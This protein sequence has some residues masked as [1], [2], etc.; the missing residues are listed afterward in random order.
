ML[1]LGPIIG[2]TTHESTCIWIRADRD[3]SEFVLRIPSVGV[4]PFQYTGP[5]ASRY[6]TMLALASGLRSDRRY[7]YQIL[8]RGRRVSGGDGQVRTMPPPGSMLPQFMVFASCSD[9][10]DLKAW[11]QLA[12]FVRDTEPHAIFLIGDQA[13]QD[14]DSPGVDGNAY[15]NYVARKTKIDDVPDI[16]A[17]T[18]QQA[19]SRPDVAEVLRSCPIYMMWDDHDIRDGWGSWASD[20]PTIAA[21]TEQAATLCGFEEAYFNAAREMAWH[22]QHCRNPTTFPRAAL[23]GSD[24]Q[25]TRRFADGTF[26]RRTS[27]SFAVEIG[28]AAYV[29]CDGRGDR[30]LWREGPRVLGADQWNCLRGY[31]DHL[32][33]D[34]DAVVFVTPVPIVSADPN[35]LTQTIL[36]GRE[37]DVGMV[38]K[39]DEK[40]LRAYM[41]SPKEEQNKAQLETAALQAGLHYVIPGSIPGLPKLTE[42]VFAHLTNLHH[43]DIDDGR[44]QWCSERSRP[45]QVA[46]IRLALRA[47][48]SNRLGDIPRSTMFVGG[49]LHAAARFRI[50]AGREIIDCLITSGIS[51]EIKQSDVPFVTDEEFDIAPGLHATRL[52]AVN[53]SNFGRLTLNFA[54]KPTEITKQIIYENGRAA[55]AL[56]IGGYWVTGDPIPEY[57]RRWLGK[58]AGLIPGVG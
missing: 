17:A 24:A 11:T 35:G 20:S 36:K 13:Y 53:V 49:D 57:D 34:I 9:N 46:L 19:W 56:R 38:Q 15:D 26:A 12:H 48:R 7:T 31:V 25:A 23:D 37:Y 2:H 40:K 3:P 21:T 27:F 45:E 54:S 4:F 14:N 16:L 58:I 5:N 32:S 22:F 1:Q 41:S 55:G 47:R 51:K 52:K 29:M 33:Q 28:R 6:G 50:D 8:R 30:D 43:G 39:G 44:D 10:V 42:S 18:Y